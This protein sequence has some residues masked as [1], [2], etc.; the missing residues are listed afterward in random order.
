MHNLILVAPISQFWRKERQREK[1]RKCVII[2]K[3]RAAFLGI[4]T[5]SPLPWP[6]LHSSAI[7]CSIFVSCCSSGFRR[8]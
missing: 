4:F 3:I 2:S 8:E 6:H 1:E 7:L 5:C